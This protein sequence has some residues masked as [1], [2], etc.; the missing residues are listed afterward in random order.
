MLEIL[1]PLSYLISLIGLILWFYFKDNQRLSGFMQKLFF[2]GLIV[3]IGSLLFSPG[4]FS[5]KLFALF[6]DLIIMGIVSQFFSFF[7]TSKMTF[8]VM[9]LVLIGAFQFKGMSYLQS[10]FTYSENNTSV[11][12]LAEKGELLVE[13]NEHNSIQDI[14]A[15]ISKYDLTHKPSFHPDKVNQTDLDDYYTIDI[16]N[17]NLSKIERI[18]NDLK[19]SNAVD[20]VEYNEVFKIEPLISRIRPPGKIHFGINDPEVRKLWGFEAMEMEK[21]YTLLSNKKISPKKK[22]KVFIVDSGVDANHED[23][24]GRYRSIKVEY[25]KDTNG[26]GTH[27]AGIA[28]A[29]TNN[30]KGVASVFPNNDFAEV[31]GI[32]VMNRF[33]LIT[34]QRLIEGIIEAVDNGADVISVS[35]GARSR[36]A[37]QEAFQEVVEYANKANAIIVVAAGNDNMDA[38]DYTPANASGVITVAAIDTIVNK[39]SFSNLV[40]GLEMGIAAPGVNIYSTYPGSNYKALSGTS[41]ACPYVSGLVGLMKS[42]NPN[43]TS[44]EVYEILS[45]TGIETGNTGTTG[46]LIQPSRAIEMVISNN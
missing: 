25:D 44:K 18:I 39:A 5:I 42:I 29:I 31:S 16:P 33:G 34:Q 41:M 4:F 10:T 22:A 7:K 27:C 46:K 21:L 43:L 11:S 23:L 24:K 40:G 12:N 6:R 35:I 8:F 3:Y 38:R 13:I 37:A 32:K 19:A 2:S 1:Y 45:S 9:L 15:I 30:G 36:E 14:N 17:K 28:A 26:H 20:W